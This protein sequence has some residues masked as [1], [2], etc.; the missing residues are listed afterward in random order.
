MNNFQDSGRPV[1]IRPTLGNKI[2]TLL[3]SVFVMMITVGLL[4]NLLAGSGLSERNSFLIG[5]ALQ[6]IFAFIFPAYLTAFLFSRG[7]S[8]YLGLSTRLTSFQIAAALFFLVI[9]GPFLNLV[10]EWNASLHL[11]DSMSAVE[12][13]WREMEDNAA[14]ISDT[15]LRDSSW[16]GL[17]SG[18]LF[19]GCLTGF[20]EEA[21]F[22]GGLQ[23]AFTMSGINQH[24]AVW[25]VAF[26]FSAVHLQF[27]GFV[28]R[29]ILGA[30]FGYAY[31]Y[32]GS[33][34]VSAAM[35]AFN[36]SSVVV[37][38]WLLARHVVSVNADEVGTAGAGQIWLAFASL[39]CGIGFII[40]WRRYVKSVKNQ[41][42]G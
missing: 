22:R 36:N 21:L 17:I 13:S 2:A 32:S 39:I 23:K 28:P 25:A 26:I 20:A 27:F 16:W 15:I 6:N 42:N 38:Q 29:L 7:A 10:I 24:V 40:V 37:M 19:V 41:R 18:I 35:H 31:Y 4:N 14:R 34:W 12:T 11:P 30:V 33:L 1:L 9:I 8:E 5:S 3:I